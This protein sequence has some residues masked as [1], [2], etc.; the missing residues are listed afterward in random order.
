MF[1]N[2]SVTDDD[3]EYRYAS[4]PSSLPKELS[5]VSRANFS[6]FQF[7]QSLYINF[8]KYC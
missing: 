1:V 4:G 6:E 3:V 2:K 5:S 8:I 7:M